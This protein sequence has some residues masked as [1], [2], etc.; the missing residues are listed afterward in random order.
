MRKKVM[1]V[2]LLNLFTTEKWKASQK[3]KYKW[4]IMV[5]QLDKILCKSYKY[6]D[7]ITLCKRLKKHSGKTENNYITLWL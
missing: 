5:H 7:Y 6:S 4:M 2:K 1:H 3:F